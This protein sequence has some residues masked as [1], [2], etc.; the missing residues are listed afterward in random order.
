MLMPAQ[1]AVYPLDDVGEATRLVQTN[2]HI[3][4]IG[5]LCLAPSTGLGVTD[6]ELRASIGADRI[7]PLWDPSGPSLTTSPIPVAAGSIS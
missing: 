3:G 1:S 7:N 4:K 2:Q 5:V 6:P